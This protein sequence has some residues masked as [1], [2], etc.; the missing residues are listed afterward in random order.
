M[1]TC[2]R[3]SASR[4]PIWGPVM[5][6]LKM[7]DAATKPAAAAGA[8][9]GAGGS[10]SAGLVR[11]VPHPSRHQ[12]QR[13]C[14]RGRHPARAQRRRQDH[15]AEI[16]DGD[17]RQAHRLGPLRRSGDHPRLLGQDRA[18][19]RRLLPGGARDFRQPRRPRKPAVAAD[20]A[21]RR[22]VAGPDLRTVSQSQ[23]AAEQ[24]GHQIVR[25]RAADAGDRANPAHRRAV[26][27]AGR[28]DRRARAGHHPAD[29]P[30]HRAAQEG[31]FYHPSGRAEFPLRRHRRRSLLH[32][33]TR[34]DHR[35]FRQCASCR[36][37]WT[38]FT[39][40][41]ASEQQREESKEE[42]HEKQNLGRCCSARR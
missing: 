13:E 41:S 37:T 18:H 8:D 20:R 17:H 22:P 40:I 25:R 14:R 34:Q 12:F 3:T 30:H 29:R 38:S 6:D 10:G 11:R 21:Q 32:R 33:R 15:H 42:Q 16:G 23:G 36:P 7:A 2:P 35:R 31:R 26:S 4:K 28:A 39:P 24:P 1:P 9:A 27:D 5:A 19:G